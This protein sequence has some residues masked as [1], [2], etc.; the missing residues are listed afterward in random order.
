MLLL[1]LVYCRAMLRKRGL[2]FYAVSVSVCLSVCLSVT[3]VDS[4]ET[5]KHNFKIF[6]LCTILVFHTKRHG[7]I[8][9]GTPFNGGVECRWGTQK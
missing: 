1:S 3:F 4:V 6:S 2:C 8:P 5:N 9:T 7:N